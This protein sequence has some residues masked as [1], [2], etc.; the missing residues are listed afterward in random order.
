ML[1]AQPD[2]RNIASIPI[3]QILFLHMAK[4]LLPHPAD[5][6][7]VGGAAND[8]LQSG[9]RTRSVNELINARYSWCLLRPIR[10]TR[11]RQLGDLGVLQ[12]AFHGFSE[13]ARTCGFASMT[14]IRFAFVRQE[15]RVVHQLDAPRRDPEKIIIQSNSALLVK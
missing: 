6:P 3:V 5:R 13:E 11:S 10:S 14:L 15:F 7:D 4:N 9:F 8:K 12:G 1:G 2:D